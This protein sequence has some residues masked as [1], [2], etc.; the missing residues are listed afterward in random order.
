MNIV[1]RFILSPKLEPLLFYAKTFKDFAL[2]AFYINDIFG[3]FKIYQ[4]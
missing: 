3:A 4:K 1:F 2:L